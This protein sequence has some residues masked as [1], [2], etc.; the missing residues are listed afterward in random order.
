MT[1]LRD[2]SCAEASAIEAAV[3]IVARLAEGLEHAHARGL[4]HRDLKPSNILL[5]ADGTPMLLDFNLAV[6]SRIDSPEGEI[7]HAMI[8]GTLPYMSPEHLDAFNPSGNTFSAH[9]DGRSDIYALGLIFFELLAGDPPF[10]EPPPGTPLLETL[11]LMIECRRKPPSARA[12]CPLVPWSLDALAAKCIAFDPASRYARAHDLA[13]DLRR[14]LDNLPMKHCPEPSVRERVGKFAR[15]HPRLFGATSIGLI[16]IVLLGVLGGL[17]ALVYDDMLGLGARVRYRMFDQNYT[18]IQF[19]L[20]TAGH[21]NE[22]LKTGIA[23]AAGTL[24]QLSVETNAPARWGD[25]VGRLA[26]EERQRLREQVV[27]LIMLDARARVL[28][29]KESGSEAERRRAIKRAIARLD[30]AEQIDPAVPSALFAERARYHAALGDVDQARQDR[31]R[32]S[33]ITPTTCH[34]LTLVATGLLSAGDRLGAE[35]TLK[36]ALRVDITSF[37]AWFVL[38]HCHFAQGR[39]VESAGDFA[40]CAARA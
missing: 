25:W 23:K 2:G 34:D 39:F 37:W 16:T 18:E 26:P 24:A 28:L 1:N 17:L 14:F 36:R 15:R 9:V 32:S 13:E 38:G 3:W 11:H 21:S 40:A 19:L 10:P 4:L 30:R 33:R 5:A 8:G 29:A 35:Q 6:S 20:N 31:L 22:H 12:R 7:E 27:E